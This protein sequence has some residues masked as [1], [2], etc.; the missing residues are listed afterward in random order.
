MN[1]REAYA[2]AAGAAPAG[3]GGALAFRPSEPYTLGVELELQ[4]TDRRDGDLTHAAADLLRI[5]KRRNPLLDVKLEITESMIEVATA[6]RR[7]HE[8]LLADLR[9]L[10][11]EVCEAA[12][13]LHVGVCGGG[14]HPFQSWTERRI[15]TGER[16]KYLSD[17]YGYLAKQFT[18]F[19]QHVHVGCADG[20]AAVRLVHGLARYVPQFIA[21]AAS[22]PFLQ[23][24]DTQ[25]DCA[26]MNAVASFPL[27]GRMPHVAHWGSF[28][29]YFAKM[30][31]TGIVNS[32]KDFYWDIRP[33]PEYGT[34][35]VR[36]FDTPLCVE[37]AA[38]LAVYVQC[39]ARLVLEGDAPVPD[40]DAYL[41][42]GYNRFQ[43]CRF[44]LH[45]EIVDPLT[46]E[47]HALRDD[48]AR[49]IAAV[50]R[51]L[52]RAVPELA[53]EEIECCL[54]QGNDAAWLR[55]RQ[56]KGAELGA[57]VESQV[58]RFAGLRA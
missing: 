6:V 52:L 12:E 58:R 26:R 28:N 36:V 9:M 17:L 19:G 35:E 23:G 49:T 56:A 40:E 13:L 51:R 5:V 27:S 7:D 15:A 10:R 14:T 50:R 22:S 45:A 34:V 55:A 4:L 44:G 57:L 32:M 31:A 53:L 24:E 54:A 41:V 2:H 18:V 1:A 20:D 43:A 29:D 48:V 21:L 30:R 47:R 33:K 37:R 25:F 38:A 39:L 46:R 8:G 42:Y 11:D 3:G 16:M